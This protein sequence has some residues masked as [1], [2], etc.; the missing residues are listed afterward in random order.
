MLDLDA[1]ERR[2]IERAQARTD[3]DAQIAGLCQDLRAGGMALARGYMATRILHPSYRAVA[4]VWR[5][6]EGASVDRLGYDSADSGAWERSPFKWMIDRRLGERRFDL[7][8]GP[9]RD[10]FPVLADM[11]ALG[12]TDYLAFVVPYGAT[13]NWESLR[14]NGMTST[15]GCDRPGGFAAAEIAALRRLQA[16]LA[17]ALRAGVQEMI[18]RNVVSTYLGRDAGQRVLSG[19]IRRGHAERIDAVIWYSDL[20]RSTPL[21][22]SMAPEDFLA[23]L[24][25]SFDCAAGA[26]L[27]QGGEVLRFIGDAVL[28]IFPLRDCNSSA[29]ACERALAAAAEARSRLAALN[30]QRTA[31]GLAPLDFGIGL[32]LGQVLFGN[33]GVA[34]RLEFT[35]VGP[36]A[37][38]GARIEALGKA[39]GAPVVV[40]GDFAAALPGRDWR[41]LGRHGLRGVGTAMQILA[42]VA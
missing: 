39:M 6:E 1:V 23:L 42:P 10:A 40:S 31:A 7:V 25:D 20:R 32:H 28:A 24:N 21:A 12:L 29:E 33:I 9:D 2:L 27:D 17:L 19:A 8:D 36:A 13:E 26:V 37:N 5:P 18:A 3:F 16:P 4:Y 34:E 41:D 35:V 11:R 22:E 15:W 14:G 38:A 30:A